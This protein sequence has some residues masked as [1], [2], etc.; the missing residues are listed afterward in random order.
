MRNLKAGMLLAVVFACMSAIAQPTLYLEL[1]D[2]GGAFD[3]ANNTVHIDMLAP[4]DTIT[5][6]LKVS[7]L[8]AV[9]A[10]VEVDA[11]F[12]PHTARFDFD[13]AQPFQAGSA[14][15]VAETAIE[16]PQDSGNFSNRTINNDFGTALFG[17]IESV[18]ENWIDPA[19]R[20]TDLVLAQFIMTPSFDEN[21]N[22]VSSEE[23]FEL[24]TGRTLLAN[25][26]AE[27][28]TVA[29]GNRFITFS[30]SNVTRIAGDVDGN[31]ILQISDVTALLRCF[32]NCGGPDCN[33]GGLSEAEQYALVD[34]NCDGAAAANPCQSLTIS[35]IVALLR[36]FSTRPAGPPKAALQGYELTAGNNN[37]ELTHNGKVA[38]G[39]AFDF[40]PSFGDV[41]FESFSISQE[42]KNQ[43]WQLYNFYDNSYDRYRIVVLNMNGEAGRVPAVTIGYSAKQDARVNLMM[44]DYADEA[45]TQAPRAGSSVDRER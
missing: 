3:R 20:G 38:S 43:G 44:A 41:S 28:M 6:N 22:C 23:F 15:S 36:K 25:E 13:G 17:I 16:L 27:A 12:P 8:N 9:L 32:S 5:I 33:F 18:R 30:N 26:N 2:D 11:V 40:I 10:G 34:L 45:G 1:Q 21:S 24:K 19:A 42:A 7:G 29:Y 37:F 35:D 4:G 39:A 31:G 14:W